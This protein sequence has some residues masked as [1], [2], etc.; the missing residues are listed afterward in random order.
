MRFGFAL[1]ASTLLWATVAVG[2]NREEPKVSSSDVHQAM[3]RIDQM[4]Q[5]LLSIVDQSSI[6]DLDPDHDVTR[7]MILLGKM[8]YQRSV[9]V[10]AQR[11]TYMPYREPDVLRRLE[12]Y[13]Y[14]PA[15]SAL[16]ELGL[17]S[18]RVMVDKIGKHDATEEERNVASWVLLR[19]FKKMCRTRE[20]AIQMAKHCVEVNADPDAKREHIQA[21][22]E[23]FERYETSTE[24]P[25]R[26]QKI[27][28]EQEKDFP[29][30]ESPA[31]D[32]RV[33]EGGGFF[34]V[35]EK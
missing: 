32:G 10:L 3:D 15:A 35:Q 14:Y 9:V 13:Q 16:V 6:V 25:P 12:T 30:F 2:D 33:I 4:G 7:A 21:A 24:P 29:P 34:G 22:F 27:L 17:I 19:L 20:Q 26:L 18:A 28:D 31:T 8:K 5:D 1:V 23:F 11:L